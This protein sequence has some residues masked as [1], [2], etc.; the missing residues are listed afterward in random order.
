MLSTLPPV[1][2][3]AVPLGFRPLG[4]SQSEDARVVVERGDVPAEPHQ[5]IA[6]LEGVL[7]AFVSGRGFEIGFGVDGADTL[8]GYHRAARV[9]DLS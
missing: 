1:L 4:S 8:A 5:V 7:A 3:M 6:G 2:G 9:V